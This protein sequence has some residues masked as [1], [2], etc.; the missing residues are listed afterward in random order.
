MSV[1]RS[2][3]VSVCDLCGT[4]GHIKRQCPTTASAQG[5]LC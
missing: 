3:C 2:V 1:G 5:L 4:V